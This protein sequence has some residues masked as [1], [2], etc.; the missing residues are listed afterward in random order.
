MLD[1]GGESRPA[2]GFGGCIGRGD[3]DAAPDPGLADAACDLVLAEATVAHALPINIHPLS[4][5]CVVL[6]IQQDRP[7]LTAALLE[8][9]FTGGCPIDFGMRL[10][11]RARS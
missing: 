9:A 8:R 10:G 5:R 2:H 7:A 3:I 1:H 4:R 11:I 6:R